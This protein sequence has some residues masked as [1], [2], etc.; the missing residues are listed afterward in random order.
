MARWCQ[1]TA[2]SEDELRTHEFA[3][4][5]TNGS[6]GWLKTRVGPVRAR[7]PLPEAAV[8][9]LESAAVVL[10]GDF[11]FRFARQTSARPARKSIGF[12]PAQMAHWC[13]GM[14]RL[15][16]SEGELLLPGV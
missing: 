11:P 4:V 12:E 6:L 14:E 7:G 13:I 1:P 8:R 2:A 9:V 5:F 16:S 3:V 10:A 15:T